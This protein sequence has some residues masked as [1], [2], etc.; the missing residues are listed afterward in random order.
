MRSWGQVSGFSVK[1]CLVSMRK[2]SRAAF[3]LSTVSA[4]L[5]STDGDVTLPL[6]GSSYDAEVC[7]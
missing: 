1:M 5:G 6:K 7:E 2:D 4:S 3:R